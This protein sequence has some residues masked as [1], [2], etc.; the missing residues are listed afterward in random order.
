MEHVAE[1]LVCI[2]IR[3]SQVQRLHAAVREDIDRPDAVIVLPVNVAHDVLGDEDAVLLDD[4]GLV[5]RFV[6][7]DDIARGPLES[8]I[9]AWRSRT[10]P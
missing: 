3:R 1:R 7:L 8:A 4:A 6:I 2:W 5:G 10:A 9:V